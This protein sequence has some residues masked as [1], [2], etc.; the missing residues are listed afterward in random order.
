[1]QR[2]LIAMATSEGLEGSLVVI[3][4][5]ASSARRDSRSD[6]CVLGTTER[7]KDGRKKNLDSQNEFFRMGRI[8][9]HGR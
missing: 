3:R 1:M 8:F 5:G 6:H 7:P 4:H 2:G 9:S